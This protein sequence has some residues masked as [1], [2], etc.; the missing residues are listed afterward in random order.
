MGEEGELEGGRELG[1]N[2]RRWR[3]F[4]EEGA[5]M[6]GVMIG[7]TSREGMGGELWFGV[8]MLGVGVM[9]VVVIAFYARRWWIGGEEEGKD[10][11]EFTLEELRRLREEG[12]LT[13]EEFERM[14]EIEIGRI[15]T[16]MEEFKEKEDVEGKEDEMKG[17]GKREEG[18]Q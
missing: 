13:Q 9:A 11:P 3:R 4:K 15:R 8:A 7:Q 12:Q 2:G 18:S 16:G 14:K 5:C 10:G 17:N 6:V 1:E